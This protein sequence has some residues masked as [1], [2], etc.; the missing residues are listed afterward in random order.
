MRILIIDI[1][2]TTFLNDGGKIIELGAVSLDTETGD[3]TPELDAVVNPGL[4]DQEIQNAWGVKNGYINPEEIKQ[5]RPLSDYLPVLQDLINH[6]TDGVTAYN[7]EF[8][9]TFLEA[10]GINFPVKLSCPMK[11][12]TNICKIPHSSGRGYKWPK[13]EEAYKFFFPKSNYTELHRG[14]DDAKHEAEIV[15]ELIKLN[16][17]PLNPVQSKPSI[18]KPN[19]IATINSDLDAVLIKNN[20]PIEIGDSVKSKYLPFLAT[21]YEVADEMKRI[22]FDNPT[23]IDVLLARELR[24]KLVPNRTSAD[25]FKKKEKAEKAMLNKLEDICYNLIETQ[26]KLAESKL[27]EVE[28][29]EANKQKKI[30]AELVESRITILNGLIENPSIYPLDKMTNQEFENFVASQ[31]LIKSE[32]ERKEKAV[33]LYNSRKE[34]LL[35]F[36]NYLKDDHKSVDFSELPQESFDII[37]AEAIQLVKLEKERLNE[38]NKIDERQKKLGQAGLLNDGSEFFYVKH[39]EQRINYSVDSIKEMTND[40]FNLALEFCKNEIANDQSVLKQ[41]EQTATAYLISQGFVRN[42]P[43]YFKKKD[44]LFKAEKCRTLLFDQLR[45]E[46]E[47]INAVIAAR[48]NE[49]KQKALSAA[50]DKEKTTVTVNLFELPALELSTPEAIEIWKNITEKFNGLKAWALKEIEKIK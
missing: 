8:D 50:S 10:N 37:L 3:I 13:V 45:D 36:W 44:V 34:A 38:L 24:L 33:Q 14:A 40:E 32:N 22:N 16:L 12:S 25:K 42:T 20:M 29:F 28:N 5:A 18:P 26:S 11:I 15:Y 41:K 9:F 2:T 48:E 19:Q 6:F 21:I 46:V 23:E 17:F 4:T 27:A 35:P 31:K 30:I 43:E 39:N 1:E 7:N 49:A 47:Q